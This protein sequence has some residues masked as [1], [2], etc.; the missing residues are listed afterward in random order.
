MPF[1]RY[2][3]T[4]RFSHCDP[5]GIV[6]FPHFFTLFND[7]VEDWFTRGLGIDYARMLTVQRLGLPAAHWECDFRAPCFMGECLS[8]DLGVERIGTSSLAL[9][10][11]GHVDG[12][13]RV[14]ARSVQ[15]HTSLETHRP[16][17]ISTDWRTRMQPY[18]TEASD[19]TEEIGA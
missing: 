5:A 12:T 10:Y 6:F 15:V 1:H 14:S 7:V 11:L 19:L 2:D 17:A 3:V 8:I 13:P 16:I 4:I 18:L 9:R